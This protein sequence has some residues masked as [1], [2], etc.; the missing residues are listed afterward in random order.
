[1]GYYSNFEV[2]DTD[3]ENILDVLRASTG[4]YGDS[5]YS[6]ANPY[7]G[8]VKWYDWDNDLEQIAFGY[9]NNYLIILRIG[10]EAP[11]ME[12][13]IVRNGKVKFQRPNITWPAE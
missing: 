6:E 8:S 9:P 11:D 13:A 3:I 1:M 5:W 7:M 2:V 10:E 12:R 4:V